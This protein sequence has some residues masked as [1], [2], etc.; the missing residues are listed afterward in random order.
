MRPS[1][2]DE[3]PDHEVLYRFCR[4][5]AFPPGQME[6]PCGL[7]ADRSLSCD[8]K[9]MRGDPSTSRHVAE[10][11][12][13]VIWITVCDEIRNPRNPK[14]DGQLVPE[15]RQAITYAPTTDADDPGHAANDAHSL[16]TGLKKQPVRQALAANST[17]TDVRR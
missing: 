4:P 11:K 5:E 14:R 1:P 6:I 2:G 10:G 8:W 12:T 7:F 16:V 17:W 3:I 13:R 9:K 15:W